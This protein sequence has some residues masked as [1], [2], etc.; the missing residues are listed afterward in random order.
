MERVLSNV[1]NAREREGL[2][3]ASLV[4]HLNAIIV[5]VQEK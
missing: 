5:M 3:V 4:H 1:L 2:V